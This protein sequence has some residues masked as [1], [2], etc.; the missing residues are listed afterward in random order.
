MPDMLFR[1]FGLPASYDFEII[2]LSNHLSMMK[3]IP[4]ARSE[5]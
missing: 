4:N 2:W 5:Q 3:I 1:R